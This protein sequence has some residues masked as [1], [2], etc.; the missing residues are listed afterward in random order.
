[1]KYTEKTKEEL[2]EQI[3][4]L[5]RRIE[6]LE[7]PIPVSVPAD[8]ILADKQFRNLLEYIP[9]SVQ[10]YRADGTVFYWNKAS[11]KIYGYT[12]KEAIGKYLGDLIVPEKLMP[13]FKKALKMGKGARESGEFMPAGKLTLLHKKGHQVP[14][15]SIHS[16]VCIEGKEPLLFCI[17]VDLSEIKKVEE[18]L[19][20][21][22]RR[23]IDLA[24]NALEWIWEADA[25]GKYTYASPAVKKILGYTPTEI[26]KKYFYDLFQ[27]DD[28]EELK[29]N[30]FAVFAQKKP[31][32]EFINRNV[33]K[34]GK[35]VWLSTSGVPILDD[36][37][38]LLGY[39]GADADITERKKAELKLSYLSS[40]MEHLGEMVIVTDMD[41]II[42]YANPAVERV[43]GY[44]PDEMI[45]HE[46]IEFFERIDGNPANLVQWISGQKA[47]EVWRGEIFNRKKDGSIIR[48]H[49]TLNW[50]KDRKGK[51]I[52]CVGVSIDIT[53]KKRAE[54][55]LRLLSVA[56]EQSMEGI[57]V[58]D[59][60]GTLLFINPAFAAMHGYT[61]EEL[62]GKH[63]SF[64]H[65]PEQM[66]SIKKANRQVRDSGSFFGEI[67]H[68]RRDGTIFPTFMQNTILRD[69]NGDPIGIIG[70]CRDI[71][72]RKKAEDAL[73]LTQ[74]C[75][76][77]A[78]DIIFWL[79]RNA[80]F[81]YVND[82][83]CRVL[84]Y[85][86]NEFLSMTVHDIDPNFPTEKWA[87]HW[88]DL[89]KKR[90][91]TFESRH[92]TKDGKILPV[93][94]T[95]NYLKF[96]DKE[97]HFASVRDIT[98]RKKAEDAVRASEAKLQ[99]Q[100]A[101]LEQKNV[102]LREILEQIEFEKRKI[103]DDVVANADLLLPYLKKLRLR[104]AS[105]KYI[106]LLQRKLGELADSFGR[107]IS[108][109]RLKLTPREIEI[110]DMIKNGLTS[111]EISR[112]LN[113][114]LQTIETHRRNIRKKLGISRK[115]INLTSYL[116]TF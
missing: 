51:N 79:D 105:R 59:L 56:I 111:K 69:A 46:S 112:L 52:G 92:R 88:D 28:R 82:A 73:R 11:E 35:T 36:E 94:I 41:H 109:V 97:Y 21:R 98:Q 27:P 76:D 45:G 84:G 93:E 3:E 74:F 22:E 113:I 62:L 26:L 58:S 43:L 49:L 10:G 12:A 18:E 85:S 1:M 60:G 14:V 71:T 20:K 89:K 44:R 19:R 57:A 66:L 75:I 70:A 91:F 6:S 108:D 55:R 100:K 102:A 16:A 23:F 5:K 54:E 110:C 116:Q 48:V 29:K 2:I 13:L 83:A 90:F 8:I 61:K 65:L 104:G 25:K 106:S 4:F 50:L 87:K 115:S 53:E 42:T 101:A 81:F 80:R 103:K 7:S 17:D 39:R 9:E 67:W 33:H 40:T 68:T 15:Y 77:H 72:E 37:G 99:E 24:E 34:N 114:S 78:G 107:K 31:F 96:G 63:L 38:R 95:I 30:S 86:R 47:G 32:R 64:F